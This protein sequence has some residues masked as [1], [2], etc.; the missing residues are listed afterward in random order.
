MIK[1]PAFILAKLVG[2][3]TEIVGDKPLSIAEFLK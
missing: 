3:G 2:K 1:V